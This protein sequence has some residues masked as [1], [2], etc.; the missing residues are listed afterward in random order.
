MYKSQEALSY[1][2]PGQGA[3]VVEFQDHH[4]EG[5]RSGEK[6]PVYATGKTEKLLWLLV[7]FNNLIKPEKHQQPQQEHNWKNQIVAVVA[8]FLS[9]YW[10]VSKPTIFWPVVTVHLHRLPSIHWGFTRAGCPSTVRLRYS[11][12]LGPKWPYLGG[13]AR[14]RN[15]DMLILVGGFNKW[16]FNGISMVNIWLMMVNNNLVGGIPT[17]LKNMSSSVGIITIPNMESHKIHVPNHQSVYVENLSYYIAVFFLYSISTFPY[18]WRKPCPN[19]PSHLHYPAIKVP[20][21]GL[22]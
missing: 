16:D 8:N 4:G 5:L 7:F 19:V 15:P 10:N 9:L 1:G 2:L 11:C 12:I 21:A 6:P 22:W 18:V 17:P 20:L 13:K 14:W 3:G